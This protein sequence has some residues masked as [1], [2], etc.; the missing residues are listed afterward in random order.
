VEAMAFSLI[1]AVLVTK[2]SGYRWWRFLG[3][4]A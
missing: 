1:M 4:L 2:R 3:L